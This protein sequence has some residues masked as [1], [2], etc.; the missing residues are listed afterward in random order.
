MADIRNL[1][2]EARAMTAPSSRPQ[3]WY[4]ENEFEVCTQARVFVM[5]GGLAAPDEK[6]GLHVRVTAL[7][8][9]TDGRIGSGSTQGIL[10]DNLPRDAGSRPTDAG[11]PAD[12]DAGQE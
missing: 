11:I 8:T 1:D 12:D 9:T 6:D 2:T 5:T 3:L 4:C 10:R 7:V